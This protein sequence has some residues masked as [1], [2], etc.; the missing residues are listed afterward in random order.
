M[1]MRREFLG[2]ICVKLS[3]I[4]TSRGREGRVNS[5][6]LREN[7][8]PKG[9]QEEAEEEDIIESNQ[10]ALSHFCIRFDAT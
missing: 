10:S 8:E 2:E 6:W 9:K 4:A 7:A 1:E 5:E 3:V